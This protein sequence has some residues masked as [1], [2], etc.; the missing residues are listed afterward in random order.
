MQ[1]NVLRNCKLTGL[2]PTPDSFFVTNDSAEFGIVRMVVSDT[3]KAH[4]FSENGYLT[5]THHNPHGGGRGRA[6]L[7]EIG[8]SI[9]SRG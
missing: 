7:P 3:D 4:Y 6:R 8:F 9:V 5:K 1:K 2:F